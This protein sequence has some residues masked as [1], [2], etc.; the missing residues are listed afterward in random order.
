VFVDEVVQNSP[1]KKYK[2]NIQDVLG[3]STSI[4]TEKERKRQADLQTWRRQYIYFE[5]SSL[6]KCQKRKEI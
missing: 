3:V 4:Q 5:N 6:R 1:N 2:D